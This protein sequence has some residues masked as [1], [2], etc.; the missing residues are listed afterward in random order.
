MGVSLPDSDELRR[1]RQS[2]VDRLAAAREPVEATE[3][4]P[5]VTECR[6]ALAGWAR[7]APPRWRHLE[8]AGRMLATHGEHARV[9][10]L[11]DGIDLDPSLR[12]KVDDA[13]RLAGVPEVVTL[14]MFGIRCGT[15]ARRGA[16]CENL[17]I[18][19]LA[20]APFSGPRY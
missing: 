20:I 8:L 9:W 15:P 7:G 12:R 4:A 19:Q 11:G 18:S 2:Y 14:E 10:L 13:L 17:A 3:S 5:S 1:R 6:A 16:A